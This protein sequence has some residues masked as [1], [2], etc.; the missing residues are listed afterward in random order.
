ML[1]GGMIAAS[2]KARIR[3]SE[4]MGSDELGSLLEKGSV[5]EIAASLARE[6]AYA[7]LLRGVDLNSVRRSELE[8]LMSLALLEEGIVFWRYI[9]DS[10]R[11]LLQAWLCT[12]DIGLLKSHIRGDAFLAE[13]EEWGHIALDKAMELAAG[14]RLTLVDG[15]KLKNAKT[16]NEIVASVKDRVLREAMTETMSF[17]GGGSAVLIDGKRAQLAFSLGMAMDRWYF[18]R[19][20]SYVSEVRGSEG[21]AL[22]LLVGTRVDL[23]N[24]Y[25]IYRA[26]RFFALS[27]EEALTLILK[28]RF[29]AKFDVL[30]AAAFAEPDSF[31]GVLAN[32]PYA[33]VFDADP[34]ADDHGDAWR[35]VE[36]ERNIYRHL[37]SVVGQIFTANKIGFQNIA[38][39]LTLKETEMRDIVAVIEAAR[40]G[41]NKRDAGA[42][43]V[44]APVVRETWE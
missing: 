3:R 7:Q 40:Y 25:W 9:D 14:Y 27:P 30:S 28:A 2:V 17:E 34:D 4:L 24:L 36:I 23:V 35:E 6:G 26:R 38:A 20:Y 11:R 12:F 43:L 1:S 19:L 18:D 41:F 33:G 8:F 39:Y 10:H 32:T 15:D 5:R 44:R 13:N 22:R 16:L 31:S 29:R 42:I 37:M 21:S